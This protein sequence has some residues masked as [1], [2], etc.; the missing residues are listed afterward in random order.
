MPITR[1]LGTTGD[2]AGTV[3]PLDHK[4]AQSGLLMKRGAGS[5]LIRSGLFFDTTVNIVTGTSGMSYNVAAFTAALSRGAAAGTVLLC[6]DGT[7]NVPTTAAPGSN[8]RI[9]VV[10]A[11][12]REFSLDGV[13][14][15]P[16][17]GVVQGTPA[18]VPVAP[19]LSAFPGAIELARITVPAGVTATN[20]GTTIVQSTRF[21]AA[22]G[23]VLFFRNPAERD[24]ALNLVPD[25]TIGFVETDNTLWYH[26]DG[27]WRA[28]QE[29]RRT[30]YSQGST[31]IP[32]GG[33]F[34]NLALFTAVTGSA[35]TRSGNTYTCQVAG[36]YRIRL[37]A[38]FAA[39]VTGNR[40]VRLIGSGSLGDRNCLL[41]SVSAGLNQSVEVEWLLT[42]A[43]G[44]SVNTQ[45]F[46]NSGST[47]ATFAHLDLERIV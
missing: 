9:D 34:Q 18:A 42:M 8:S 28:V 38:N 1:G 44:D 19:S 4:L 17:I 15:N 23:G 3:T 36:T 46:Q 14:S 39:N 21:T 29:D 11:W 16:V 37:V 10:Y 6:N 47:L 12:Q 20:S 31:N 26:A 41:A 43:V 5:N 22:A 35:F 30:V 2:A 32:T 45:V 40:G 24:E 25:G 27:V 33:G 13:D 7:V